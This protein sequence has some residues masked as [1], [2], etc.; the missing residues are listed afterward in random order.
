LG[1]ANAT[2]QLAAPLAVAREGAVNASTADPDSPP[3]SPPM[4]WRRPAASFHLTRSRRAARGAPR[5][6]RDAR[7][8]VDTPRCRVNP[9]RWRVPFRPRRNRV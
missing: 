5:P 9:A 8:R 4:R 6:Q 2:Q 3:P 7:P 1:A